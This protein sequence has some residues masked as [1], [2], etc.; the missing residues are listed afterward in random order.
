[1]KEK[2]LFHSKFA[3]VVWLIP[4]ALP[5][6][7]WWASQERQWKQ[8]FTYVLSL[9]SWSFKYCFYISHTHTPCMFIKGVTN[10][11]L[12][13][14]MGRMRIGLRCWVNKFCCTNL[15]QNWI[16]YVLVERCLCW[17]KILSLSK[18]LHLRLDIETPHVLLLPGRIIIS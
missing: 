17:R 2:I 10:E 3:V 18:H 7:K 14:V 8:W 9:S 11:W 13:K 15:L 6:I 5:Q 12:I 4:P 16:K 1:M